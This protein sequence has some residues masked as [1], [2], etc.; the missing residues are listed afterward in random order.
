MGGVELL[1][2]FDAGAAILGDLVDVGAFHEAQADV[3]VAQAVGGAALAVAVGL[4]A[5]F[6]ENGVE[7]FSLNVSENEVSVEAD[8]CAS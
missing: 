7:E 8:Y 3:G 2:H 4:E 6:I 1:D 5:K